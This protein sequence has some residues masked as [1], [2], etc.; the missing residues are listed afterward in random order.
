[1]TGWCQLIARGESKKNIADISTLLFTDTLLPKSTSQ[2]LH[3]K[4]FISPNLKSGSSHGVEG[5]QL[6]LLFSLNFQQSEV[7][8]YLS[9]SSEQDYRSSSF[10]TAG[11]QLGKFRCQMASDVF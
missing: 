5:F 3:V 9:G 8:T 4:S 11:N 10:T 6:S 7:F 2:K 1:M